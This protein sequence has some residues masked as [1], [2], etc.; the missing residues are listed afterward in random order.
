MNKNSTTSVR[1]YKWTEQITRQDIDTGNGYRIL[2]NH[3][4]DPVTNKVKSEKWDSG[5]TVCMTDRSDHSK[6]VPLLTIRWQVKVAV[7]SDNTDYKTAF[8]P[9]SSRRE[10]DSKPYS[11]RNGLVGQVMRCVTPSVRTSIFVFEVGSYS[12]GG[13]L[14]W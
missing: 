4:V 11:I 9:A 1:I 2:H 3:L 14:G 5:A 13:E 12:Q 8:Y 7:N 6:H 10:T